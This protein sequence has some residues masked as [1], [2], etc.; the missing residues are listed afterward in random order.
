MI[1]KKL[2]LLFGLFLMIDQSFSI[3]DQGIEAFSPDNFKFYYSSCDRNIVVESYDEESSKIQI[4]IFN[5]TGNSIYKGDLEVLPG[6]GN[7]IPIDLKQG[8]YIISIKDNGKSYSKK[9]IIK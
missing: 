9:I 3:N 7:F 1:M 5:I 6:R 2:L 8:L 4:E